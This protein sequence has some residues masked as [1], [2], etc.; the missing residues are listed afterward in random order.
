VFSLGDLRYVDGFTMSD[1]SDNA[2]A[3][4]DGT[5]DDRTCPLERHDIEEIVRAMR[6]RRQYRQTLTLKVL[7]HK[8]GVSMTTL[9]RIE[10]RWSER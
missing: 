6:A 5:D 10:A 9:R 8:F 3:R 1:A 7:A 4:E 2:P